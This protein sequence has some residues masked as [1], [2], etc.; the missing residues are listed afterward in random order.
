MDVREEVRSE[1][2]ESALGQIHA[3]SRFT[4]GFGADFYGI[5]DLRGRGAPVER[6]P[7]TR[8]GRADAVARY[9]ELEPAS[10][11]TLIPKPEVDEVAEAAR[12]RRRRIWIASGAVLAVG[13]AVVLGVTLTGGDEGAGDAGPAVDAGTVASVDVSGPFTIDEELQQS[14]MTTSGIGTLYPKVQATWT[15]S[16]VQELVIIMNNPAIGTNK[17]N[18]LQN[19]RVRMTLNVSG[20]GE[21][22]IES[23]KGECTV[24]VDHLDET[25]F[26]GSFDCPEMTV[27]GIE[28]PITLKGTYGAT[29]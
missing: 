15:G 28:G 18:E 4:L 11:D 27:S 19:Q 2:A 6:F 8:E 12:V 22:A 9:V 20:L 7:A 25:G 10:Q 3:G 21:V 14:G 5:W 17:T 16:Q 13:M 29:P 23:S 26:A 24:V 1:G